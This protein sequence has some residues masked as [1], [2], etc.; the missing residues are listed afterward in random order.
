MFPRKNSRVVVL[1]STCEALNYSSVRCNRIA[2]TV[3]GTTIAVGDLVVDTLVLGCENAST[4]AKP[5]GVYF[6]DRN[7][8]NCR[9]ARVS[10]RN[11]AANGLKGVQVYF[12]FDLTERS[13]ISNLPLGTRQNNHCT[14]SPSCYSD[15]IMSNLS[16]DGSSCID[17]LRSLAISDERSICSS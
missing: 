3:F 7:S 10:L 14:F 9:K 1:G 15:G 4:F 6:S 8:K 17:E 11:G 5:S 2:T 12:M 16:I 13:Y